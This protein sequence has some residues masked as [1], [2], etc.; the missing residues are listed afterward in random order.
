MMPKLVT[1]LKI[2]AL[3]LAL[4]VKSLVARLR[5]SIL[6]PKTAIQ[7]KKSQIKPR[8]AAKQSLMVPKKV[9]WQYLAL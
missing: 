2:L 6:K 4:E 5:L 8:R 1:K 7:P 3:R 9:G